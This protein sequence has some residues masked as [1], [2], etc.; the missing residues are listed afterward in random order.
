[1]EGAPS[2]PITLGSLL[3]ACSYKRAFN[4]LYKRKYLNFKDSYVVLWDLRCQTAW[5]E[6][7][8]L[9]S[10]SHVRDLLPGETSSAPPCEVVASLLDEFAQKR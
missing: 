1:M 9:P 10:D 7:Q 4:I 2:P 6:L 8:G 3:S 5:R